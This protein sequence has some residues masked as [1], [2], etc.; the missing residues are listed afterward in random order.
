MKLQIIGWAGLLVCASPVWA[1]H[2]FAAE[3]DANKPVEVKGVIQKVFWA[4]PHAYVYVQAKGT[5]GKMV[6]WAFESL[7]PNALTKQGWNRYSLKQG[8]VVTVDGW[9]ARDGKLLADGSIHANSR[10]IILANGKK[11]FVG[12][13]A[14][15]R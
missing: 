5:D 15:E 8:D 11:V 1:H 3:Y 14:E 7:S 10:V 13:S 9:L 2:A 6:T 12:S 4:N